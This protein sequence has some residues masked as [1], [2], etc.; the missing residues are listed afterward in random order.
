[1]RVS[2]GGVGAVFAAFAIIY[3]S[4]GTAIAQSTPTEDDRAAISY[5]LDAG[6]ENSLSLISCI[7][8]AASACEKKPEMASTRGLTDC[9]IRENAVWDERLNSRYQVLRAELSEQSARK[10]RDIQRT[11]IAWRKEKCELPYLLFEGG[12]IA[13]VLAA[14]CV[15]R[16]TALR[17]IELDAAIKAIQSP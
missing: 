14:Q 16:A 8:V 6:A 1:M 10:L 15:M 11:W 7:G 2:P 9:S 12:S 3:L 4:I 5:C 13:R 17:A